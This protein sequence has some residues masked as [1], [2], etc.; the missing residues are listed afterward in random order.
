LGGHIGDICPTPA[1]LPF[2]GGDGGEVR[3][4]IIDVK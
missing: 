3:L 1:P 2:R 4:C